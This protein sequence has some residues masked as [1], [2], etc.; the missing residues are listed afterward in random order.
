MYI[1]H[2]P[3]YLYESN[4]QCLTFR[5]SVSQININ[6]NIYK[7]KVIHGQFSPTDLT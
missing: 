4:K 5:L 6:T 2:T 7:L 3:L 1:H